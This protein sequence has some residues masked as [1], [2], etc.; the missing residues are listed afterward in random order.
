MA[1]ILCCHIC[2][3]GLVYGNI[4]IFLSDDH[5]WLWN[6][7]DLWLDSMAVILCC[8]ICKFGLVYGNIDIFLSDDH[9]WIYQNL[10]SPIS[11]TR[12][13]ILFKSL[14]F[15]RL[16]LLSSDRRL[17]AEI[18]KVSKFGIFQSRSLIRFWWSGHKPTDE[19]SPNLHRNTNGTLVYM[20]FSPYVS[21]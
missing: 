3:F 19:F 18:A 6:L 1:V 16:Q 12:L 9:I 8:H 4:D 7:P 14:G 5:I 15:S 17:K 21:K 20:F 2:K 10:N 13:D 11:H